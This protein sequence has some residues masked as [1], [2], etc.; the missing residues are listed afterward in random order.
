MKRKRSV[1]GR[2][3]KDKLTILLAI[4]QYASF[5]ETHLLHAFHSV[6]FGQIRLI[7]RKTNLLALHDTHRHLGL[8]VGQRFDK[9]RTRFSLLSFLLGHLF[10]DSLYVIYR[11]GTFRQDSLSLGTRKL[12]EILLPWHNNESCHVQGARRHQTLFVSFFIVA[13]WPVF[14]T[15]YYHCY[16]LLLLF[17]AQDVHHGFLFM[18]LDGH[19]LIQ[20]V[21]ELGAHRLIGALYHKGTDG[22]AREQR[23]LIT[24]V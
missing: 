1:R 4:P 3:L 23:Y 18:L 12:T 17:P 19:G 10:L 24:L 7:E 22:K 8:F 2:R 13:V 16:V 20:A 5:R 21:E 6:A 9:D 11:G 15:G 14:G